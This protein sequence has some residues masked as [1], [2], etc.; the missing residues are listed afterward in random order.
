MLGFLINESGW[1]EK[2][3]N[4]FEQTGNKQILIQATQK[5][6]NNS[7]RTT[8]KDYFQ[9]WLVYRPTNYCFWK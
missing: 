5:A 9:I 2:V 6:G 1:L 7:T 4:P 3:R 8:G